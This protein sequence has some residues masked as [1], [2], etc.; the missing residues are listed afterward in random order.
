MLVFIRLG[1]CKLKD[2]NLVLDHQPNLVKGSKDLYS[3]IP[4]CMERKW[5]WM[6]NGDSIER[7]KTNDSDHKALWWRERGINDV[8]HFKSHHY[9]K[10]W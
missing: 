6:M 2:D 1:Q 10:G 9:W 5:E 3:K 4:S 8:S 7:E